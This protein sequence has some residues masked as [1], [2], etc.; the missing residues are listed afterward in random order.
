MRSR[1]VLEPTF[2]Q[3]VIPRDFKKC[4]IKK[5]GVHGVATNDAD[6]VIKVKERLPN[7]KQKE[8]WCC[9]VYKTWAGMIRRGFSPSFK[10]GRPTYKDV[11]ICEEWILFS[12]FRKWW[13]ENNVKGWQLDKDI[14]YKGNLVY[15]P[16]CCVYVPSYINILLIDS[17]STRGGYPLGVY[18]DVKNNKF[19]ARVWFRGK[20]EHLGRFYTPEQAHKAWQVAKIDCIKG[21]VTRYTEEASSLG[22]FNVCIVNALNER[23]SILEDDITNGRETLVLH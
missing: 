17:A 7:G 14:L 5:D 8:L 15:S 4:P 11:S 20:Q 12:N 22:V 2:E 18:Y 10:K 21:S 13:V 19:V 23:I 9:P 3:Y 6:Y 16:E 1:D